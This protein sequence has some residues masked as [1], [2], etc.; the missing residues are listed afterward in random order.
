MIKT[1][2]TQKKPGEHYNNSSTQ[3]KK[4]KSDDTPASL[5][6]TNGKNTTGDDNIAEQFNT[7]FAEIGENLR[8]N[9]PPSR[10]DP[11]QLINEIDN[12]M[13]LEPTNENELVAIVKKNK[14]RWSWSRQ[15]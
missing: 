1:R 14:Q 10:T 11:L 9:I 12:E 3:N 8:K 5:T 4:N 6:G 7:Y 15:H 2:A 13:E